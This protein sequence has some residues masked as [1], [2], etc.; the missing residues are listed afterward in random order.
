MNLR[1]GVSVLLI[2]IFN[3]VSHAATVSPEVSPSPS[4]Q[5]IATV[6]DKP[7]PQPIVTVTDE[8]CSISS[9]RTCRDRKSMSACLNT[10]SSNSFKDL[11]LLIRNDGEEPLKANVAIVDI[12]VQL[13]EILLSKHQ[14]KKIKILA[15]IDGSPS[16]ILN[17]GNGKCIIPVGSPELDNASYGHYIAYLSPIYGAYFLLFTVLIAGGV[18]ACCKFGKNEEQIRYQELEMEQP[19]ARSVNDEEMEAGWNQGWGNNWEEEVK[20]RNE[21]GTET[22]NVSAANGHISKA[23]DPDGWENDWEN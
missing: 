11:F 20:S 18:W 4:P 3:H 21:H 8:R 23:S 5:P 14:A 16:I 12:D 17:A 2:L 10:S 9:K 15:N 19:T 22:E 1:S 6:T 7:S 13:P